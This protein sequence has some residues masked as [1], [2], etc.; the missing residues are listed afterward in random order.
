[1]GAV[2]AVSCSLVFRKSAYTS[3]LQESGRSVM[4]GTPPGYRVAGYD[5][6]RPQ[7]LNDD[8]LFP[9]IS[10]KQIPNQERT[11]VPKR[12]ARLG[13]WMRTVKFRHHSPLGRADPVAT[14]A[15]SVFV[16]PRCRTICL[17]S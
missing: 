10:A 14:A 12:A 16:D 15:G 17:R 5:L 4:S 6:H 8:Q 9:F 11:G 13:W 7:P 2:E 3:G 1:M